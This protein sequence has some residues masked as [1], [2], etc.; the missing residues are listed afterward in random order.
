MLV[1][2]HR[3][4]RDIG[5]RCLN[6]AEVAANDTAEVKLLVVCGGGERWRS[7]QGTICRHR[8]DKSYM[9]PQR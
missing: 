2:N 5:D 4:Y 1:T 9:V 6:G 3:Y 7:A 8:F